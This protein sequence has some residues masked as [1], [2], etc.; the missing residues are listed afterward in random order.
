ME[1]DLQELA[2]LVYQRASAVETTFARLRARDFPTHQFEDLA[3]FPQLVAREVRKKIPSWLDLASDP[4]VQT[5]SVKRMLQRYGQALEFVHQSLDFVVNVEVLSIPAPFVLFLQELGSEFMETSF[6]LQAA[7]LFNYSF[8]RVAPTLNR[9]LLQAGLSPRLA[10]NFAV[11]RFPAALREDGL[12]HCVLVHEL[13]HYLDTGELL[14]SDAWD[15]AG[16]A[17]RERIER[18]I[19]TEMGIVRKGV[20]QGLQTALFRALTSWVIET[21]CDVFAARVLGPAYL[22][23]SI[24]FVRFRPDLTKGSDTHP[25]SATRLWIIHKEVQSLGWGPDL[26]R[27]QH[28]I[29]EPPHWSY[30][31]LRTLGQQE[32]HLRILE[33]CLQELLPAIRR[34]VRRRVGANA[35]KRG[36]Y[37]AQERRIVEVLACCVPPGE[38]GLDGDVIS[39][40]DILNAA[41]FFHLGGYQGWPEVPGSQLDQAFQKR[42]LLSRLV[43]KA[44]EISF[45][46][47]HWPATRK[48]GRR[49]K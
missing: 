14:Y 9:P 12:Q 19:G 47:R 46:V 35:C 21:V 2:G 28:E 22:F 29:S 18:F 26:A 44:L 20:E 39:P 6:V 40:R 41:W 5:A 17:V 8:R 11:F 49:T 10:E 15:D 36:S 31:A 45:V 27:V 33:R 1:Q 42:Q 4:R 24:E 43:F 23:S 37:L 16:P 30:A 13:G 25:P 32:R 38:L 7:P 3:K 34:V 48:T